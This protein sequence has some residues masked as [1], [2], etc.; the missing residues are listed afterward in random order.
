MKLLALLVIPLLLLIVNSDVLYFYSANNFFY[1]T[2]VMQPQE[3]NNFNFINNNYILSSSSYTSSNN[4]SIIILGYMATLPPKPNT[5]YTI[6][7]TSFEINVPTYS[8][9]YI[10]PIIYNISNSSPKLAFS[11]ISL[12]FI[13]RSSHIFSLVNNG[14]ALNKTFCLQLLNNFYSVNIIWCLSAPQPPPGTY[15]ANIFM[16]IVV[17]ISGANY[18]YFWN[19]SITQIIG[20]PPPPPQPYTYIKEYQLNQIEIVKIIDSLYS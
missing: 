12:T 18:V 3:Y 5:Y 16:M 1:V 9:L 8:K 10:I 20:L 6:N 11:N 4:G 17:S 13:G 19:L 15:Y 2:N 14:N 7:S